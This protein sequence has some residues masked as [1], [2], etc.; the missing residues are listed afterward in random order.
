MRAKLVFHMLVRE[1]VGQRATGKPLRLWR[2]RLD[3]GHEWVELVHGG[4][5]IV[6]VVACA[7]EAQVRGSGRQQEVSEAPDLPNLVWK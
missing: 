6:T 1:E 7:E 3:L 2:L 4:A 5:G